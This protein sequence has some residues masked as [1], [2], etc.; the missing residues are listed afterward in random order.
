VKGS[1]E[2]LGIAR[3][4]ISNSKRLLSSWY[5]PRSHEKAKD[6]SEERKSMT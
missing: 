2:S 4:L 5:H 1:K 3:A 6:W